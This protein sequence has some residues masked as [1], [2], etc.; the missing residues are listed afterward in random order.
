MIF[1][2]TESKS[3]SYDILVIK[4][5]GS[6][7]ILYKKTLQSVVISITQSGWYYVSILDAPVAPHL[8]WAITAIYENNSL[9][10]KYINISYVPYLIV[11][12]DIIEVTDKENYRNIMNVN[13]FNEFS[14]AFNDEYGL[15]GIVTGGGDGGWTNSWATEDRLEVKLSDGTYKQLYSNIYNGKTIFAGRTT[16]D[17]FNDTFNTIRSHNI[18]GGEVDIF[19][20]NIG[21]DYFENKDIIGYRVTKIGSNFF[22]TQLFGIA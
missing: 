3:C 17:F 8:A 7:E 21:K 12:S 20:E 15:Y 9:P 14:T 13:F 19:Y 16:T 18:K 10:K 22:K 1:D 6:Y 4:P 2:G 11:D 5:D